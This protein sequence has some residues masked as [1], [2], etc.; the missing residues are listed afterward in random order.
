[1]VKLVLTVA[2]A[3][4]C[5]S[6]HWP[7]DV[8]SNA[9][10]SP[11]KF[12]RDNTRITEDQIR[13]LGL[14]QKLQDFCRQEMGC[15][16]LYP[17]CPWSIQ[18]ESDWH[19]P[20][21]TNTNPPYTFNE[22]ATFSNERDQK[23]DAE[24]HNTED[25]DNRYG[26]APQGCS[27][28]HSWSQT[29]TS[30]TTVTHGTSSSV[31]ITLGLELPFTDDS[32]TSTVEVSSSTGQSQSLSE[33]VQLTDGAQV[34]IPVGQQTCLKMKGQVATMTADWQMK[35][36]MR[37]NIL[38]RFDSH[39]QGHYL[40]YVELDDSFYTTIEGTTRSSTSM[41][42]GIQ[43]CAGACPGNCPPSSTAQNSSLY[44]PVV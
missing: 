35:V 11:P 41:S 34:T 2:L 37:G 15:S 6:A 4:V 24:T 13:A 9:E 39:C 28:S 38:C 43:Q 32:V 21:P 10:V 22:D 20:P 8:A 30:E 44:A 42:A 19:T 18:G 17:H 1:M 25:C 33:D 3:Q 16:N 29:Q 5:W 26:V 23:V 27:L 14:D 12:V 36:D 7:A 40:W 31:A